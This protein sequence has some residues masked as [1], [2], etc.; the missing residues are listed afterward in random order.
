VCFVDGS[1]VLYKAYVSLWQLIDLLMRPLPETSA[2]TH[3]YVLFDSKSSSK[4]HPL[5]A[6]CAGVKRTSRPTR[7]TQYATPEESNF[8]DGHTGVCLVD[9]M[10]MPGGKRY[11]I[12]CV[13]AAVLDRER[14][15]NYVFIIDG[16]AVRPALSCCAQRGAV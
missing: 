11:V 9:L 16:C 8:H 6:A 13:Q 7:E 15:D 10:A 3:V 12:G 14:T 4:D 5:K 2:D 1:A